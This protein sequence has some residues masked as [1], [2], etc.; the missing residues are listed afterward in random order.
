MVDWWIADGVLH[1]EPV[2]G[3]ATAFGAHGPAGWIIPGL[4]DAHCH[5]GLG[6]DGAVGLDEAMAQAR[7]ERDAGALLLRDCGS[8]TDT[9]SLGGHHDLPRIIR[10][11]RH[12]AR[13][14]RYS[15]GYAVELDDEWGCPLRWPSRPASVTAG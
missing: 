12:L 3:A 15:R 6:P 10:A 2:P 8:P 14:K 13:P 1:S 4:V 5:V 7:T 9:R 11:G